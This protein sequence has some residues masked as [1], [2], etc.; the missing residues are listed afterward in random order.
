AGSLEELGLN[1]I[2]S[3][4]NEFSLRKD[5]ILDAYFALKRLGLSDREAL[6]LDPNVTVVEQVPLVIQQGRDISLRRLR[7]PG[8]G[9]GE[10]RG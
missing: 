9:S 3:V 2:L 6:G 10:G 5:L 1:I 4:E 8:V 7:T